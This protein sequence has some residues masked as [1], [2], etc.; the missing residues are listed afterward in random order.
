MSQ[1]STGSNDVTLVVNALRGM[2]G[3]NMW[4]HQLLAALLQES[5]DRY[6]LATD[7]PRR[8]FAGQERERV[9]CNVL[10]LPSKSANMTRGVL[11]GC[12]AGCHSL[13]ASR[14]LWCLWEA[15]ATSSS[16][17]SVSCSKS[18]TM[19]VRLSIFFSTN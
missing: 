3:E 18:Y 4:G 7:T 1:Q 19:Q 8:L 2:F 10:L 5:R 15:R 9:E 11:C 16:A 12:C 6:V 14:I 13:R 17:P